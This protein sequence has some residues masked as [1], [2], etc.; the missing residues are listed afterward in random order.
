MKRV[1]PAVVGNFDSEELAA[2]AFTRCASFSF[3]APYLIR[4]R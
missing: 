4:R 2:D 1:E 3:N